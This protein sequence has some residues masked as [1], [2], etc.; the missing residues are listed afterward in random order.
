MLWASTRTMVAL[1]VPIAIFGIFGLEYSATLFTLPALLTRICTGSRSHRLGGMRR[2]PWRR[3]AEIC[4]IADGIN[5]GS[6]SVSQWCRG[7]WWEV[8]NCFHV[9]V[10]VN[11]Y[12]FLGKLVVLEGVRV[13]YV[14]FT[15]RT[16]RAG[17][18]K[19]ITCMTVRRES[20]EAQKSRR[21]LRVVCAGLYCW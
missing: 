18:G 9:I 4:W 13:M 19:R 3:V 8:H 6:L 15:S 20:G 7:F 21:I 1:L 12:L 16:S 10:H 17:N 11:R 2:I 5:L 14:R